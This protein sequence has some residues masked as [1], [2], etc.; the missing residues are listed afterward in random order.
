MLV[1]K[2]II[3]RNKIDFMIVYISMEIILRKT[4]INRFSVQ[5]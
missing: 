2:Q 4:V 5:T 1:N 3:N